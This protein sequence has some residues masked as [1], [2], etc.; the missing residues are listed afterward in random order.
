[1]TTLLGVHDLDAYTIVA[2]KNC[3]RRF[4]PF[5]WHYLDRCDLMWHVRSL[6]WLILVEDRPATK[7]AL[8]NAVQRRLY[9]EAKNDGWHREKRGMK[10][11][12]R[13]VAESDLKSA[14]E[15]SGAAGD[16]S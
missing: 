11:A 16:F 5:L 10:Y 1:M 2:I 12:Q 7:R 9:R 13:V 3:R 14:G 4:F 8:Y 6:A 15:S